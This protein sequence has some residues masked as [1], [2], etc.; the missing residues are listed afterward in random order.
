MGG[1]R[2]TGAEGLLS[3]S[4]AA[5]LRRVRIIDGRPLKLCLDVL[6]RG[7]IPKLKKEPNS[8]PMAEPKALSRKIEQNLDM[9]KEN[10][11]FGESFD[12]LLREMKIGGRRAA[13]I[14]INGLV[15]NAALQRLVDRLLCLTVEDILPKPATR[16][17]L[18][19]VNFAEAKAASDVAT[20]TTRVLMGMAAILIDGD[21]EAVTV[22]VRRFPGRD[23]QEP[24]LEKVLRGPR[25]GFV[26]TLIFNTALLRRRLR[27]PSLRLEL[28]EIGRRSKTNVVVAYVKDVANLEIVAR[29]KD[30]LERID[31]D[32]LPMAEKSLEEFLVGPRSWI[33][34]FP[35]V[36]YTE[37][38]DVAA[39]HLVE[40][41]VVVMVDTS[42]SAMIL[43]ATFFHHV[44][45]AEEYRENPAVGT[46]FRWV[47]F[48]A[49][50][51]SLILPPA[52]VGLAARPD[53]LPPWLAFI[54]PKEPG[55]I[56]IWVQFLLAEIGLDIIRLSLIHTP[57]SLA[58]SLGFIGTV[59]LGEVA[60][61]VGLFAFETVLYIALAALG[62][63]ATP[64][65]EFALAVRIWRVVLLVMVA[66][67]SLPGLAGGLIFL[68]LMLATTRSFG[69][70]YLWPLVPLDWDALK[71]ILVRYPI[72]AH[73][74]RPRALKPQDVSRLAKPKLKE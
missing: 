71:S 19:Q 61:R 10:I 41:H 6:Q 3:L 14:W 50:A 46:Y 34:P 29:V 39:V 42:P 67:F 59:L 37:R 62:T 25:D 28:L 7:D 13:V 69:V 8:D 11:G 47:R 33:N 36:R 54:G 65:M 66:A 56:P 64:S 38:P 22:D 58:T 23:P 17:I 48:I 1:W 24:D 52:W 57:S 74:G 31:T 44:Q 55:K 5:R 63:F 27:D 9:L 72:P 30:L 49:I 4:K 20:T 15:D 40:G 2:A 51:A 53:V 12:A 21:A 18:E 70:P 68:L 32:A 60:A 35:R 73:W 43:P 26:E 16:L 45:H